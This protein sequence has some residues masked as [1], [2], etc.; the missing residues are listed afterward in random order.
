MFT[1]KQLALGHPLAVNVDVPTELGPIVIWVCAKAGAPNK[2]KIAA[3]T[4]ELKANFRM[5]ILPTSEPHKP[6]SK[7]DFGGPLCL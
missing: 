3:Q 4:T 7:T 6:T 5:I 2:K 1:V